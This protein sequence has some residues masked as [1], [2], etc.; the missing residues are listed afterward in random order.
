MMIFGVFFTD[1]KQVPN[2]RRDSEMLSFG[3]AARWGP[4]EAV[5]RRGKETTAILSTYICINQTALIL[6]H[7]TCYANL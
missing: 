3:F 1:R 7:T 2:D 5:G 4:L 6:M